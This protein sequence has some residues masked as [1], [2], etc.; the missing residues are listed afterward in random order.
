MF[1]ISSDMRRQTENDK[2]FS[3][4]FTL[5]HSVTSPHLLNLCSCSF[6]PFEFPLFFKSNTYKHTSLEYTIDDDDDDNAFFFDDGDEVLKEER[7]V[8]KYRQ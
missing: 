5:S 6:F 7:G 8:Q 3:P 1:F 2:L 4:F